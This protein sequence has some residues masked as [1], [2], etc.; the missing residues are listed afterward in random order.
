MGSL[1]QSKLS[2]DELSMDIILTHATLQPLLAARTAP[3]PHEMPAVRTAPSPHELLVQA[4]HKL[5]CQISTKLLSLGETSLFK[6]PGKIQITNITVP[7]GKQEFLYVS[8]LALTLSFCVTTT[9]Q[10]AKRSSVMQQKFLCAHKASQSGETFQQWRL[11][12]QKRH[13]Q[14]RQPKLSRKEPKS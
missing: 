10:Q 14:N 13:K 11:T 4:L 9:I 7:S 1:S 5:L 3:S 6:V 8:I 12:C 2:P